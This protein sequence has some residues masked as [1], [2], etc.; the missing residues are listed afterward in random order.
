MESVKAEKDTSSSTRLLLRRLKTLARLL[1]FL[2]ALAALLLLSWSSLHLPDAAALLRRLAAAL[3]SP[4]FVFFLGN[5]IVLLLFADSRHLS[6]SSSSSSA[7]TG[8]L[9]HEYL[10]HLYRTPAVPAAADVAFE[11]KKAV[12]VETRGKYRRSKSER[13]APRRASPELRRSETEIGRK[14]EEEPKGPEDWIQ[15]A[16][17]AEEFRR[18]IE[19][20]IAKQARFHRE[21]SMAIVSSAGAPEATLGK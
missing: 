9:N 1:R 11:D 19:A 20:F 6:S 18:T 12:R 16:E 17:D 21:E 5:A 4:R 7:T 13:V 14:N 15:S 10:D 8:D 3:L 2:E